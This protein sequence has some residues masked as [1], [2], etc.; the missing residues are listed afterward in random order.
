MGLLYHVWSTYISSEI[1]IEMFNK[2]TTG[3][4]QNL[5]LLGNSVEIHSTCFKYPYNTCFTKNVI[6]FLKII[7]LLHEIHNQFFISTAFHPLNT[8][9][10]NFIHFKFKTLILERFSYSFQD[11]NSNLHSVTFNIK[12]NIC[13]FLI[14]ISSLIFKF[15][16]RHKHS[17]SLF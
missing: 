9:K 1:I 3:K 8:Y 4:T 15:Q 12:K 17:T 7:F 10:N 16:T 2:R 13:L 14:V 11:F 5:V 6:S